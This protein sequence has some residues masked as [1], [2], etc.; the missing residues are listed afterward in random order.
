MV[1]DLRNNPELAK[2]KVDQSS[3]AH[4]RLQKIKARDTGYI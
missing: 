3:F 1:P 4:K 2:Q